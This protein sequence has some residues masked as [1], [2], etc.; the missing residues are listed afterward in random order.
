[1]K[2]SRRFAGFVLSLAFALMT[3]WPASDAAAQGVKEI[4]I[5]YT[6]PIS[7]VAAEYGQ[8]CVNGIEMAI[9]EINPAGGITVKG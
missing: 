6:G 5:G 4:V 9:N 7:G 2:E 3:V 8:D 1:M